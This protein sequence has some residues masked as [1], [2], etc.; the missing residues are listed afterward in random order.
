M[1]ARNPVVVGDKVLLTECYG[2]GAA[3]LELKGGK[4]KEIWTDAEKD[5][6][7]QVARCATGTRRSTSTGSCTAAAAGT[8]NDA[9]LRCVELA[10]GDVKWKKRRT[11]AVHAAAGGRALH[12]P[13]GV[14]RPVADQG[15]PGEV[16]G[17]VEVRGAGA[18]RT[19]AGRR[20]C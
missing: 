4:P 18:G 15:E 13:G 14:R 19:R 20:R 8:T 5:R 9:D 17:G 16:R 7:R 2:P 6:V 1:N 10:T 12:L 11:Y 3:L